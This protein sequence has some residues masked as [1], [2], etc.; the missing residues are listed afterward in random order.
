MPRFIDRIGRFGPRNETEAPSRRRRRWPLLLWLIPLLAL[1]A[2]LVRRFWPWRPLPSLPADGGPTASA[3]DHEGAVASRRWHLT[4]PTLQ[5]RLLEGPDGT[6]FMPTAAGRVEGALYGSTRRGE[7]GGRLQATFHEG[8]D[9]APTAR[10][11]RGHPLDPVFAAGD[12]HV[13]YLQS[14]AGN[15]N[16]GI[17]IVV[18]HPDPMGEVYTLYAHLARIAEG[19]SEGNPVTAG[20]EIGRMGHTPASIVP[21]DRAHLHF[22]IGLVQNRRFPQWY[23]QQRMKPDHGPWHGWNLSGVDPLAAFAARDA[24][25][26]FSMA[27]VLA[28][29]PTAFELACRAERCPDYFFR[30]PRLWQGPSLEPGRALVLSVCAG[31]VVLRGRAAAPQEAEAL[32]HRPHRVIR[33]DESVLGEN[34]RRLIV[35]GGDGWRLGPAGERWLEIFLF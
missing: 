8:I 13:A 29:T 17:Y 15:S 26:E 19:L 4:F 16:Y 10:D 12:G 25:G 7:S 6:V 11:R 18:R 20:Q 3:G 34:G 9:I 1:D 30:Y 14:H 31:G 32:G 28:S 33:V 5:T 2:W 24:N 27:E 22:E 23:R 21:R 35:R